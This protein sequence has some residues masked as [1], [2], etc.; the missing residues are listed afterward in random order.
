MKRF[1]IVSTVLLLIGA[2]LFGYSLYNYI[3]VTRPAVSASPAGG[4]KAQSATEEPKLDRASLEDSGIFSANYEKAAEDAAQ[5][6]KEQMIGQ[7]LL[8]AVS[9]TDA[10]VTDVKRY[11]LAGVSFNS[12]CFDYMDKDQITAAVD[13]VH[14]A[15]AISPILAVEEEG[16]RRNAVSSHSVFTDTAFDSPRNLFASGGLAAVEKAEDEKAQFLSGLGFNLNLAPVVDLA[17]EFN[18]IMYSRSLSE[19]V[20]TT[21]AYA[22]YVSRFNQ[23]KGV[24]VTLKH[25]PGYGTL[26]DTVDSIVTDTR[27]ASAIRSTDYAPFKAGANA[28]A[29][30]IMISN[31][32][33]QNIDPAHTAALSQIMHRELRE[34]VGFT[35]LIIADLSGSVDYSA[36]CDGH[37][38]PVAAVLAGNDLILTDDYASAYT[39]ILAAVNDGTVDPDIIRQACTRVLAY[40]YTAGLIE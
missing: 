35:G 4:D 22:E 26:P 31:V 27:D 8:G 1:V 34:E 37:S 30:C 40:K 21:S 12:E 39:S 33:I 20:Q 6:T 25:F 23:A 13:S 28:G 9:S 19:D 38:A 15:P 29:H 10:A 32:V 5:M 2:G 16:G 36:Y 11:S 18:H 7:L 17:A 24:S 3:E 14:D